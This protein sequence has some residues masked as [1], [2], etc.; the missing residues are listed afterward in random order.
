M[1]NSASKATATVLG[2]TATVLAP[3]GLVPSSTANAQAGAATRSAVST[4][5]ATVQAPPQTPAVSPKA[6]P[7]TSQEPANPQFITVTMTESDAPQIVTISEAPEIITV[8]AATGPSTPVPAANSASSTSSASSSTAKA[9]ALPEV[10]PS[11]ST[12]MDG[13]PG[14][15]RQQTKG[16]FTPQ[17]AILGG[18]PTTGLDVPVT[19][20]FLILFLTGAATHFTI[21]E[22]NGKR[23]HKFHISDMV[24]D[25]CMVR[26]VTCTMR[27][28]W[29]FRPANNSIVLA[30]LI[31]ENAG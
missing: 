2:A 28:V 27:I 24:F 8:T 14:L 6:T 29:A 20:V 13:I 10:V 4:V 1:G 26:T 9:T 22:L 5:T 16:P 15:T 3:S 7:S 21:H 17:D 23:G 25:F 18:I 31:F 30:A 12:T 11:G 19:L